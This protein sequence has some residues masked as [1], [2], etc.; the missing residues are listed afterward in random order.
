MYA[1]PCVAC[2]LSLSVQP[3]TFHARSEEKNFNLTYDDLFPRYLV[4]IGGTML[5]RG[6]TVKGLTVSYYLRCASHD[7][8][9]T[10]LQFCRWAGYPVS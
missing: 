6:I 5:N 2:S 10:T 8:A 9:D 4:L 1:L 7:I 3:L